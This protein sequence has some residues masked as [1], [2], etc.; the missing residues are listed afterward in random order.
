MA[1][2]TE[3]VEDLPKSGRPQVLTAQEK[4]IAVTLSKQDGFR[5]ATSG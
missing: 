1:E 4:G 5:P 3:S 2:S